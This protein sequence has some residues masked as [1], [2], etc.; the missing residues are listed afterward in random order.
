MTLPFLTALPY[1]PLSHA[2]IEQ[3]VK[4]SASLFSTHCLT[5]RRCVLK[6]ILVLKYCC[7][8][9]DDDDVGGGGGGHDRGFLYA[10]NVCVIDCVSY[11][12]KVFVL[13]FIFFYYNS[14]HPLQQLQQ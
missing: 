4:L 8:K 1:A 13:R 7:C 9:D 10:L 2:I 5:Y 11:L 6:L 3:K 12:S 14:G